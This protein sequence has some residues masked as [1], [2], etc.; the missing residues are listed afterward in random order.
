MKISAC[1]ITLNE[2]RNLPRCLAGVAPLVDDLLIVDSGSSDG[3]I[4][5]AVKYG[6]RVVRQDWLG[7]VRQKN[8]ALANARHDWVLSI[9]A[10]EEISPELA[11]SIA[12]VKAD[13]ASES[14]NAPNGYQVSRLVYYRDRWIRHGDW[15]P[16]RLVRL[17]RRDQARFSGGHVHEKLELPGEHPILAGPLRHFTYEDADDRAERCARY[18]RLWAQTAHEEHRNAGLLSGPLH[19]LARFV[20]GFIFKRGFLD[21]A[22][23]WD[24]AVG[25][26]REAWLKYELLRQLNRERNP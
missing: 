24:I 5:I 3:T 14:P 12:R 9:D 6:A 20:K 13:P 16:D 7:Y 26:A 22:V 17:F 2:E 21:G 19:G 15:Y 18:A 25:N 8:F 23:G 1:L 4:D 11:E 10:D